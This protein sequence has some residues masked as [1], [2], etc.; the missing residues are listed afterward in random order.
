MLAKKVLDSR[1]IQVYEVV[2]VYIEKF[3][4]SLSHWIVVFRANL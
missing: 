1:T 3:S 2:V 4:L